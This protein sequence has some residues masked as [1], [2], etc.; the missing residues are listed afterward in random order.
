LAGAA[1]FAGAF[2]VADFGFAAFFAAAGFLVPA[3]FGFFGVVA[4]LTFGLAAAFFVAVFF[5]PAG[6]AAPV[7]FFAF[8]CF[9]FFVPV[10]DLGLA[11]AFGFADLAA[12]AFFGLAAAAVVVV[13]D[14]VVAA[15]VEPVVAELF[16]FAAVATFF[17]GFDPAD[18]ETERFF[19]PVVDFDDVF[20][21]FF[22]CF[23]F[24]WFCSYI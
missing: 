17:A 23:L 11:A 22:C 18:F 16:V 14:D 9:G 5:A 10:A 8:V 20:F 2:F 12:L 19:V 15:G 4:F 24:C 21:W 7:V 1:F 6:L 3:A 13:V